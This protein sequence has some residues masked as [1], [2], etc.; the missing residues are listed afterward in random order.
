MNTETNGGND[1][2][3]SLLHT[4]DGYELLLDNKDAF[5]G[6]Q[7]DVELAD[8]V[9]F[10]GVQLEGDSD[11]LL[12]YRK[13]SNGKW[14]VVCYSPANSTFSAEGDALLSL[15]TT[16]DLTIS[17]IRLTTAGFDELCPAVLVVRPTGIANVVQ[18]MK[19]SAEGQRLRI[20]SDR[21]S[22]L[23]IYSLG[24]SVFRTIHVKKGENNLDGLRSGYYII[25]NHKVFVR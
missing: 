8:D 24:G 22:T 3:I 5:I 23:R 25:N 2:K 12:T 6:F 17:N 13:L 10:K 18:G 20:I 1:V 16:G 19:M 11:H 9:T 21:D 4:D 7:F 14:R 15:T